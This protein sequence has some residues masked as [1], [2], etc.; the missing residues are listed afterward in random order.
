M[1]NVIPNE[2]GTIKGVLVN[3]KEKEKIILYSENGAVK[4]NLENLDFMDFQKSD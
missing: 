4:L 2:I 1:N 3:P